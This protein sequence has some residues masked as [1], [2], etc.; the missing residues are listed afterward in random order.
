M[1]VAALPFALYLHAARAVWAPL[2][3]DEQVRTFLIVLAGATA[4]SGASTAIS[5]VGPGFG[6][7]IGPSGNFFTLPNAAKWILSFG[8]LVGRLEILS[9]LVLFQP[10]F[11]RE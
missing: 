7:I 2:F 9:I 6:D 5:N 1:I 4:I 10:S 11:W 8:M 3:K